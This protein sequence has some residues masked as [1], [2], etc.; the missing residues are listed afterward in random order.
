MA[1]KTYFVDGKGRIDISNVEEND[2]LAHYP[3]AIQVLSEEEKQA[4]R[5]AMLAET[6]KITRNPAL[7]PKNDEELANRY[8]RAQALTQMPGY[9]ETPLNKAQ[10][11][12]LEGQKAGKKF[13]A[14]TPVNQADLY[15][16]GDILGYHMPTLKGALKY[17]KDAIGGFIT[18]LASIPIQSVSI[19]A[20]NLINSEY[21]AQMLQGFI[22]QKQ[23]Q[24]AGNT[25]ALGALKRGDVGGFLGMGFKT[26]IQSAPITAAWIVNPY[27]GAGVSVGAGATPKYS[28]LDRDLPELAQG[29]K[30]LSAAN[31]GAWEAGS[32]YISMLLGFG[33][34]IKMG[35]KLPEQILRDKI[36]KAIKSRALG[37]M[38]K[39]WAIESGVEGAEEVANFTGDYL[40]DV[41]LGIKDF[42][43]A[44][45]RDGNIN[46]GILGAAA[47]GW[48]GGIGMTRNML[49]NSR[50]MNIDSKLKKAANIDVESIKD[51][52]ERNIAA[53]VKSLAQKTIEAVSLAQSGDTAGAQAIASE[54]VATIS[55][56]RSLNA[57]SK[58]HDTIG[59]YNS[60]II[61]TI[62]EQ[63]GV[64]D[65]AKTPT[66]APVSQPIL[67]VQQ[68]DKP[69]PFDIKAILT[70]VRE[71]IASKD[72]E[73]IANAEQIIQ[74]AMS[75]APTPQAENEL[76]VAMSQLKK[77]KKE[78]TNVSKT[79][80]ST[81][82]ILRINVKET[83]AKAESQAK[84]Q[85]GVQ[86][87]P[88]VAE[89]ATTESAQP[90]TETE[91]KPEVKAEKPKVA[92]KMEDIPLE[93]K[94][95]KSL[96]VGKIDE[97]I[98]RTD[99][100][101]SKSIQEDKVGKTV[102]VSKKGKDL[103]IRYALIDRDKIVVSHSTGFQENA[104]Y[105]QEI[106]NRQRDKTSLR[107]DTATLSAKLNPDL[108]MDNPIA[109]DGRPIVIIDKNG[110]PIA[111][112]GNGR[113]IAM[114]IKAESKDGLAEYEGKLKERLADFGI[115]DQDTKGKVLVGVYY[116]GENLVE[117]A[118]LL[119]VGE[120]KTLTKTE[121]ATS[122]AT[123]LANAKKEGNDLLLKLDMGTQALMSAA[124]TPF[125]EEFISMAIPDTAGYKT[126]NG[127]Y[128]NELEDRI[129]NALFMYIFNNDSRANKLLEAYRETGESNVKFML[130]G[131]MDNLKQIARLRNLIEKHGLL[132]L[133]ITK[134]LIDTLSEVSRLRAEGV[135]L[136]EVA[137]EQ[138][139]FS[140]NQEYISDDKLALYQAVAGINSNNKAKLFIAGY[141]ASA[142]DAINPDQSTIFSS[143]VDSKEQF[144][145]TYAKEWMVNYGQKTKGKP[146]E[147]LVPQK[148]EEDRSKAKETKP[149]EQKPIGSYARKQ[150]DST[151][152]WQNITED[153]YALSD[154]INIRGKVSGGNWAVEVTVKTGLG[155][156]GLSTYSEHFWTK[157]E[158]QTFIDKVK[159]NPAAPAAEAKITQST[160]AEQRTIG[161]AKRNEDKYPPDVREYL[162]GIEQ[163]P[164][165]DDIVLVEHGKP[166]NYKYTVPEDMRDFGIKQLRYLI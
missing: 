109:S 163:D 41:V 98:E 2:F 17:S 164:R 158:A 30:L 4:I 24:Y 120:Q 155:K 95:S 34:T 83:K 12:Y 59:L 73:Q 45:F 6:R 116:G 126:D 148:L 119:N 57:T 104:E 56:M 90:V 67:E 72:A 102:T 63:T 74:T 122:D 125:I 110:K 78:G 166:Q 143:A 112:T 1:I 52:H 99:P 144:L 137:F 46:A 43:S 79:P 9:S 31:A 54:N 22:D 91:I 121:Q 19:P 101:E 108:L 151:G 14:E 71:A 96:T 42:N 127:S 11:G 75:N 100:K 16:K 139:L 66:E 106:Q 20:L 152:V 28:Q 77:A 68:P 129:E 118:R 15:T 149:E 145:D 55:L 61:D 38:G 21:H 142:Y 141:Y 117:L 86:V 156:T 8:N 105:P 138:D 140:N 76:R 64:T 33:K 146:V 165:I 87:V 159:S 7:T 27:L 25:D 88:V 114:N 13:L 103:K 128:T 60:I 132:D 92:T 3:N 135:K 154:P 49:I 44:E 133:D 160:F 65:A 81:G 53:Q 85:E 97:N 150:T 51:P 29:T 5:N 153:V 84:H 94:Q 147:N 136:E 62:N 124:N 47:G 123:L 161:E 50:Y 10:L 93:T 23:Q 115:S 111:L 70:P 39:Q 131:I 162:M 37:M 157:K 40:G 82:E 58:V 69:T 48:Q 134:D 80:N 89:N 35:S 130:N 107:G 36:S 113:L 32:E 26:F 18:S